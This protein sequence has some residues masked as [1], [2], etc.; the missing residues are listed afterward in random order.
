[1]LDRAMVHSAWTTAL[2]ADEIVL[3]VDSQKPISNLLMNVI[4]KVG[5][6][7][8][9]V[10]VALNKIDL[11]K[12]EVLLELSQKLYATEMVEK[13]FMISA[14]K[15]KGTEDLLSE[16]SGLAPK[17]P[18]HFPE[19]QLS[20]LPERLMASEITREKLFLHLHQELPYALTVETETWEVF[21]NGNIK[22]K[23]TIYVERDSQRA[24]ILGKKGTKIKQ[25]GELARRELEHLLDKKIHLFLFVKVDKKWQDRPDHYRA[26]GLEYE[27]Q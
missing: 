15:G 18:W 16:L 23:Q 8:K 1:R 26:M 19:D 24:I 2:D 12:K 25:V 10:I 20:S 22:I 17:G 21:D 13:V 11:V 6:A 4:E 9:K 27:S 7:G 14:L 5:Q 3:L